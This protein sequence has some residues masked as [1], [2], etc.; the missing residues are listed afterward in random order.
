[1]AGRPLR[2]ATDHRLGGP[3]PRQ[4]ANRPQAPP[5][6]TP[7]SLSS[8][9]P[10][11]GRAH[12]ELPPVSGGYPPPRG[13]LPT[14]SSPVRHVS[15]P[16]R[17][18]V[19]LA[20]IRHAASVDPEPGSNSP[21]AAPDAPPRGPAA[22][23]C[24]FA[25]ARSS[26]GPSPSADPRR[27]LRLPRAARPTAER[28]PTCVHGAADNRDA[29]MPVRLP[30]RRPP[31]NPWAAC[32]IVDRTRMVPSD[33]IVIDD[34]QGDALL[35]SADRTA[36]VRSVLPVCHEPANDSAART[37]RQGNPTAIFP[38]PFAV[39]DLRMPCRMIHH[40]A[41][42]RQAVL[43]LRIIDRIT[44]SPRWPNRGC[45]H[46]PG[47]QIDRMK[48]IIGITPSPSIDDAAAR[49]VRALL[50]RRQ[51]RRRGHRRR[52]HPGRPAASGRTRTA[53]SSTPS[54]DC[55]SAVAPTSIPPV[56]GDAEV[57]PTT[58]GVAPA[59]RSA[60]SSRLL[61][62]RDRARHARSLHLPRH[63]GP[64]RRLRRHARSRTSPTS[65]PSDVQHRQ[66]ELGIEAAEP[67]HSVDDRRRQS[68]LAEVYG[69]DVVRV[70]S[71]HHQAREGRCARRS[72]SPA[73]PTTA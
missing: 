39:S 46:A 40:L 21:P 9:P 7:K 2:P 59:A 17:A 26:R 53:H 29:R 32:L 36:L 47:E 13:R 65:T 55:S 1:M 66:Q 5:G 70:N 18:R 71:F 10:P 34:L 3:L 33:W 43:R 35:V 49:H 12:A 6:A 56:Y 11:G 31:R 72:S 44:R 15:R 8:A 73:G 19:R 69:A 67:S 57:H 63:P 62:A 61:A 54:T 41:T 60:S 14:C 28:P 20:C 22:V 48:P 42:V 58:Y 52:R 27:P 4:P 23:G 16:K 68:C 38:A 24:L 25:A 64:Q 51:L 37:E 45:R 50:P 30:K